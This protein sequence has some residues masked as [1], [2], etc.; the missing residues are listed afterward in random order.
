MTIRDRIKDFR[1]VKGRDLLPNP[2][3]WRRHPQAQR[4]AMRA[5]LAEVGFAGAALARETPAGLMLIDGHLRAEIAPDAELP[6]LVLDVDDAEAAKLLATFDPLGKMAEPD[7]DALGKLLAE[8]E[9]ES[10]ALGKLL[11]ELAAEVTVAGLGGGAED[12]GPQLDRAAELQKEWGTEL[13]QVW[14]IPGKAGVHRVLCGDSTKAEDVGRLMGGVKAGL[15]FT[16]PP[17]NVGFDYG[18]DVDDK[19]K[20]RDYEDWTAA[21][22]ELATSA[23]ERQTVTPGKCNLTMWLRLF[24]ECNVGCWDKGEAGTGRCSVAKWSGW[25]PIC[26]YGEAWPRTRHTDVFHYNGG[27]P[28]FGH[29]CPKP[30]EFWGDV[31]GSCLV[32]GAVVYDPFLGSGTTLIAAEQLGRRCFGMEIEPKYVAVILQR[33]KDAGLSP[34]LSVF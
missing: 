9:T 15:C 13:G 5:V 17:Y 33:A 3:N 8:I 23:S 22:F 20:Q 29:P 25:E 2:R 6:V 27:P 28:R 26:F 12:A 16:D 21:W 19:Q 1:R 30:L 4:D 14:E 34:L 18:D 10:E 7:P 11:S 32:E 24:S 31:L